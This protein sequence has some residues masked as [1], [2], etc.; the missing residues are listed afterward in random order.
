[1]ALT[2]KLEK[3]FAEEERLRIDYMRL[4]EE[5]KKLDKKFQKASLAYHCHLYGELGPAVA[6]AETLDW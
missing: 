4:K 1:M 3:E 2:T 5:K 6:Y